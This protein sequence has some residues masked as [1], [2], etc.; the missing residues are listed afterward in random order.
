MI[1][2]TTNI[3]NSIFECKKF[4]HYDKFEYKSGVYKFES[5]INIKDY[6]ENIIIMFQA[7]WQWKQFLKS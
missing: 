5:N 2:W 7:F 6:L 4:D 1:K 3:L